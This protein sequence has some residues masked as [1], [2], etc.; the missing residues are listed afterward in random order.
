MSCRRRV[1][2]RDRSK[3]I[4]DF[5]E[6]GSQVTYS[7]RRFPANSSRWDIELGSFIA[8]IQ[9]SETQPLALRID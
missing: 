9:G 3:D 1:S 6:S 5:E 7:T 8:A 2:V 4:W